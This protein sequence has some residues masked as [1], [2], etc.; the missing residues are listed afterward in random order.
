MTPEAFETQHNVKLLCK[1]QSVL[2]RIVG[3]LLTFVTP[4]FMKNFFTTVRLPF[5]KQ[6]VIYFPVNRNPMDYLD[7]SEHELIHADQQRT[8]WGLLKSF[9]LLWLFPLPI[10]F[11]GRWFIERHAFLLDIKAGRLTIEAAVY[12][13]WRF[14]GLAWPPFLMRRWFNA[15]M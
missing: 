4:G 11:S 14:Y 6:P 10:I 2:M 13:L 12:L 3:F 8:S 15:R 5:Q 1:I 7:V 9:W